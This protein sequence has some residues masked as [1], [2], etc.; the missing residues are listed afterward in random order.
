MKNMKGQRLPETYEQFLQLK[1]NLQTVLGYSKAPQF[2]FCTLPTCRQA[3]SPENTKSPAGW[4]ETQ[5][6][7]LCEACFDEIFADE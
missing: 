5:I 3:F 4:R 7:G 2:L 1:Q 6:T